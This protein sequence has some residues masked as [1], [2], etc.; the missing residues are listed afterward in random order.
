MKLAKVKDIEVLTDFQQHRAI[1]RMG[2]YAV[3]TIARMF[4]P[5][6]MRP[7]EGLL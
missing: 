1:V 3:Q 2:H 5:T 7:F 6:G 4:S